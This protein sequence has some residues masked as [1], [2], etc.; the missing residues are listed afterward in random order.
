MVSDKMSCFILIS[1]CEWSMVNKAWDVKRQMRAITSFD[2]FPS[3][4][5][6][7][8]SSRFILN[9]NCAIQST[10]N[11]AKTVVRTIGNDWNRRAAD[12][13]RMVNPAFNSQTVP[14]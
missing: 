9:I 1:F 4:C 7:I 8:A 5:F 3:C 12:E 10:S 6:L 2:K 14:P 11:R 13:A